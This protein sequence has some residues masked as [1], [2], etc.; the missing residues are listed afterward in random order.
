MANILQRTKNAFNAFFD[1]KEQVYYGNESY[2]RPDRIWRNY[3]NAKKEMNVVMNRIAVDTSQ[4]N[5]RHVRLDED[6]RFKEYIPDSLDEILRI[7][8][9]IDQT[10]RAMIQDCVYS[11]LDEGCCAI[12]PVITDV[13]PD[14]TFAY[15]VYNVR[16][17]KIVAWMPTQVRVE[18]YNEWTGR[19]ET[20]TCDKSNTVILSNPFYE[21]MNEPNSTGQRYLRTMAQIDMINNDLAAHKLDMIIQ[22]PYTLG[23]VRKKAEAERRRKELE[24][25][26]TGSQYGIGYIDAAEHIVQLNRPVDNTLWEQAKTLR[27]DFYNQLGFSETILNGTADEQTTLNYQNNIIEPIA[28]AI[29]EEMQGKWLSPTARSQKQSIMYFKD[30]FKLVPANVLAE[31]ADKFVRNCIMTSNEFRAIIGRKPSENPTADQLINPNLNHSEDELNKFGGDNKNTD[32]IQNDQGDEKSSINNLI[33][34]GN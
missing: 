8:A 14:K 21:V 12:F 32:E 16:V 18:L 24:A 33:K 6:E 25:Q 5:F 1:K 19:I 9:N 2:R 7:R 15:Q 27:T 20:L 11:L 31:S 34:G 10:G 23:N 30:R 13:N 4:L 28:N 29:V 3:G 22:V 26:M 17:G